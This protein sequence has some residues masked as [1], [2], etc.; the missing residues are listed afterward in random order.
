MKKN[1]RIINFNPRSVLKHETSLYEF[2]D[3]FSDNLQYCRFLKQL[4]IPNMLCCEEISFI[5]DEHEMS[6]FSQEE[7]EEIE[8]LYS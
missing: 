8:K 6:D 4:E 7:I 3:T 5:D 2:Y 1:L